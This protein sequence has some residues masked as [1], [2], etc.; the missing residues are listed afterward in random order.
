MKETTK[1][2][3]ETAAKVNDIDQDDN[4]VDDE[5]QLL[6]RTDNRKHY[7]Q[8]YRKRQRNIKSLE[9][10]INKLS[11]PQKQKVQQS[12]FKTSRSFEV[13]V[14]DCTKLSSLVLLYVDM[15]KTLKRGNM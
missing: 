1:E 13:T 11:S 15:L 10:V 3:N 9:E 6:P 4:T 5:A 2:V 8:Q 14:C 12:F 7:Y